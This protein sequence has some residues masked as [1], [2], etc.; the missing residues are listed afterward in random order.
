[1]ALLT[2]GSV[3]L[4]LLFDLTPPKIGEKIGTP[5]AGWLIHHL[6]HNLPDLQYVDHLTSLYLL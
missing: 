3:A 5:N 1:M 4:V 6:V 2:V